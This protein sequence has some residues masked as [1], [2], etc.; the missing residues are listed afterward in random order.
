MPKILKGGKTLT[1]EPVI[2]EVIYTNQLIN[3]NEVIRQTDEINRNNAE[4]ARQTSTATAISNANNAA[5]NAN[6]KATLA[7]T[8]TTNA[9]NATA[10]FTQETIK[11]YKPSVATYADIATTYPTPQNGWDTVTLDTSIEWRYNSTTSTWVN[12]GIKSQVDVATDISNGIVKGGGNVEIAL[13]G[14]LSVP[15]VGDLTLLN[16]TSNTDLVGAVNEVN[17]PTFEDY[18]STVAPSAETAL[19]NIVT[20]SKISTLF[21]NIKAFCKGAITIG[22]LANNLIT[23]SEGLAL[24]ARQGKVLNDSI[25]AINNNLAQLGA[26]NAEVIF[27]GI[28]ENLTMS[29]M[30]PLLNADTRTI[31]V[32]GATIGGTRALTEEE[33]LLLL[34]WK[35]PT[36]FSVLCSDPTLGTTIAGKY[37]DITVMV[38]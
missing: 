10:I 5:T 8:A 22:K 3:Q 13:D 11:I 12:I 9:N 4:I 19:S 27:S 31:T 32:T 30:I 38:S 33:V 15:D 24:D 6:N 36:G 26:L 21:S 28:Q 37:L 18:T 35:H 17:T 20:A 14:T 1:S 16:T 34:A 7:N 23:T 29:S 25:T 2:A